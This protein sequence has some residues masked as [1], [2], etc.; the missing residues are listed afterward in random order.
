MRDDL[1]IHTLAR[2]AV[3]QRCMTVF[4]GYAKRTFLHVKDAVR[5]FVMCLEPPFGAGETYNVGSEELNYSKIDIAEM[6][7][8]KTGAHVFSDEY[9]QDPDQRDYVV[10]YDKVSSAGFRN[11]IKMS[12]TMDGLVDYY[13][14]NS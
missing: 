2:D 4:Q 14:L 13:K 9:Q 3:R 6:L 12:R 10:S 11:T 5:C 7:K 8:Q 1:L